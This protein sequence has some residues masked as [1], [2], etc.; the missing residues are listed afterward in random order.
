M[1][2]LAKQIELRW[3]QKSSYKWKVY[4]RAKM[5]KKKGKIGIRNGGFWFNE[6]HATVVGVFWL[7]YVFWK[8]PLAMAILL[9]AKHA[10]AGAVS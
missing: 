6:R 7:N 2:K 1:Y 5:R 9:G 8:A 10:T 3:F 4:N